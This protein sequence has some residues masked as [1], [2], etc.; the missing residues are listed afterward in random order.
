MP[1]AEAFKAAQSQGGQGRLRPLQFIKKVCG[2]A[3]KTISSDR[4]KNFF[5]VS[6]S[7]PVFHRQ[8]CRIRG[9]NA[10]VLRRQSPIS[11]ENIRPGAVSGAESAGFCSFAKSQPPVKRVV[12]TRAKSPMVTGQRLKALAFTFRKG[13]SLLPLSLLPPLKG[14]SYYLLPLKGSSYSRTLSLSIA[15]SCFS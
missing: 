8:N 15:M 9:G 13:S 14:R 2:T 5:Q 6:H 4:L 3:G 10:D 7:R 1:V 11:G 12:C